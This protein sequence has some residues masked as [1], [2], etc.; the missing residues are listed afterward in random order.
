MF[1]FKA[2]ISAPVLMMNGRGDLENKSFEGKMANIGHVLC[3]YGDLIIIWEERVESKFSIGN[4]VSSLQGFIKASL[5]LSL[6]T[7]LN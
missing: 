1:T 7:L 2:R 4:L 3:T 6:A 5:K